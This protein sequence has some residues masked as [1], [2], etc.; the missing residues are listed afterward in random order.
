MKFQIARQS[1][2]QASLLIAI[3]AIASQGMGVIR[4]ALVANYLG[5]SV[6]YDTLLI[7]MAIPMMVANIL[8]MAIPSGGIPYLQR[9]EENSI[10][11]YENHQSSFLKVNSLI[12]MSISIIVFL[13]LPMF[14]GILARGLS[15]AE[16]DRVVLYGR[17]FCLII[18]I[19]AYEGIFRALLQFR[20]NFLFPALT[21][22][23]LNSG[24]IIILITLFPSIGTP[25][26][27]V[28]WIVGT[29]SQTLIVTIPA[30]ILNKKDSK[31]GSRNSGFDSTGYL[32]F[33]SVIAF[34]ET[35]GL[36]VDP[37]DRYLA[38]S[39]LTDGYVAA[40]YYAVI[41][42]TVPFRIFIYAV[43]TAI[44]P[45]LSE[46][47]ADGQ[48]R[49]AGQLY[50]KA[51]MICLALIPIAVYL[52]L[53]A[54]DIVRILFERGKFSG[55]SRLMTLEVLKYYLLGMVFQALFFIQLKAAF[56]IKSRKYLI[57]S[58]IFSL[59]VKVSVGLLFISIDWAFAIGGGTALMFVSNF[60]IMEIHLIRKAGLVY[61][62]QD[63]RNLFKALIWSGIASVVIIGS[64]Y[65]LRGLLPAGFLINFAAVGV[66]GAGAM[67]VVD[68]WLGIPGLSKLFRR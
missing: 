23:G 13:T 11:V 15:D 61:S 28:A 62:R 19:R 36:L 30:L 51:I 31:P 49:E 21:I 55:Q 3:I 10:D 47:F 53:F 8:F 34:A 6:E 25:A 16:L 56:A 41:I 54:G 1:I 14:R 33:L 60:L 37:F 57:Y 22:L 43:G 50:H 66:S 65:I 44:F 59:A 58:R 24:T 48:T 4:E 67:V 7:S 46:R 39:F 68:R 45:S 40:N 64:F 38:G 17:I 52:F 2:K 35:L 63:M 20:H 18:P 42:G 26:Y 5:T 32:R 27:I 12:I 9:K 29:L